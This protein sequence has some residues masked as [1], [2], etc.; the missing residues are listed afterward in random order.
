MQLVREDENFKS[1]RR[2]DLSESKIVGFN[3]FDLTLK[4]SLKANRHQN[5]QKPQL[6]CS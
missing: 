3:M 4:S 2:H 1:K 5:T 6:I